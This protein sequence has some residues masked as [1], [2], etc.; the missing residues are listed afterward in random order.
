MIQD[1]KTLGMILLERFAAE[2][3]AEACRLV[4]D[5][6]S[7][8]SISVAR[9]MHKSSAYAER[10]GPA[11]GR[12]KVVGISL[13]HG[14]DLHAAFLGGLLSGHIPTMLA[15]PSPRMDPG[16]YTD[17]FVRMLR[18][19]KPDHL[20]LDAR[21]YAELDKLALRNVADSDIVDPVAIPETGE[22]EGCPTDANAVALIQHSSGTTGRPK[23]I[24]QRFRH[25]PESSCSQRWPHIPRSVP[26]LP[27][28]RAR[29]SSCSQ[30]WLHIP[31]FVARHNRNRGRLRADRRWRTGDGSGRLE[32]WSVRCLAGHWQL[33]VRRYARGSVPQW[34]LTQDGRCNSV[35]KT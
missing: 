21:V 9:L 28:A 17:S 8:Q 22:L 20:V 12:R 14:L 33:F 2:P 24:H 31:Q 30:R 34:L 16:K 29:Q 13:Y 1:D 15:P 32:R 7:H 27:V 26:L 19:I 10:F 25:N 5:D 4:S 23:G 35:L 11:R 6:G 3:D 18:H